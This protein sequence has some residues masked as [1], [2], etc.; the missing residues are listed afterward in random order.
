M[1][2]YNDP[3]DEQGN[4]PFR[5]FDE[6]FTDPKRK[7]FFLYEENELIGF[8]LIHPYSE[9]DGKPDYVMGEFTIFPL[10]RRKHLAAKHNLR[11][12]LLSRL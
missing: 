6:Y 5:Y 9:I 2:H 12:D 10:Y 4:L 8:A 1:S 7:A 3:F 11:S